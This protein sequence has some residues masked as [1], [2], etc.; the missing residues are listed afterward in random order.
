M[1]SV[2]KI[3]LLV[4]LLFFPISVFSQSV[5][6]VSIQ[7]SDVAAGQPTEVRLQC[8]GGNPNISVEIRDAFTQQSI[9]SKSGKCNDVF[10]FDLS[11]AQ[12]CCYNY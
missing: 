3:A 7:S 9:M 11:F 5:S 10:S 12:G 1:L 6:I 2:K 4:L 8:S